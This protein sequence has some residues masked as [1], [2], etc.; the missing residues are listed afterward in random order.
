M[1]EDHEADLTPDRIA[2]TFQPKNELLVEKSRRPRFTRVLGKDEESPGCERIVKVMLA[3]GFVVLL[4]ATFVVIVSQQA[5]TATAPTPSP[6]P[7][8][9]T[10]VVVVATAVPVIATALPTGTTAP[11]L[12]PTV[13]LLPIA[14]VEP[15]PDVSFY[16][17]LDPIGY[18]VENRP[19]RLYRVGTGPIKRALI[20]AI[21]G[22]YEWNTVDLMTE[23]LQ[24]LRDNPGLVPSAITLYIVPNANPDG[25]S[26]GTDAVVAR[27]NANGVDLNRNWDYQWQITATHGTRPVSAG[28]EP[29][30]EPETR[31]LR[32]FI[33]GEQLDA[34]IFYHSA[35]TAVFQGAVIT[36][37]KT[38]ELAQYMAQAT[39]YR[40]LP[41][42]VPGQI[43][44]GDAI[45]YLADHGI[46][47]IEVELSTHQTLDWDRNLRGLKA[48][49]DWNVPKSTPTP[50]PSE[51]VVQ[52]ATPDSLPATLPADSPTALPTSQTPV[53][54]RVHVVVE[55]DTLYGIAFLYKI[56]IDEL[57]AANP[58]LTLKS[59]L[60]IG[61][62]I[63]IPT[64]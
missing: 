36:K 10:Q 27:M 1:S 9:T 26:R 6:A 63:K 28:S 40:Y 16:A 7:T 50:L 61:Q 20:G 41:D 32:D 37:S 8:E 14:L 52:T 62:E 5:Q 45:D 58:N 29:F 4:L 53:R 30:S 54:S 21:H 12:R 2:M 15:T 48:F 3:A 55:G 19:L 23:T 34:V 43:S 44:T 22:G 56:S 46:T 13:T 35:F 57:L 18:S 25:Y 59:T 51:P 31:A 11:T 47:A 64:G 49:L 38:A 42:G 24:Y 33:A 17:E 39:G 60:Q